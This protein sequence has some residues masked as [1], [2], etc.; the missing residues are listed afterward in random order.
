MQVHRQ[1]K[2]PDDGLLGAEDYMLADVG[3][4]KVEEDLLR[5]NI[6]GGSAGVGG[7]VSASALATTDP[8]PEPQAPPIGNEEDGSKWLKLLDTPRMQPAAPMSTCWLPLL[9]ARRIQKSGD[10]KAAPAYSN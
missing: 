6:G 4:M 8:G 5:C 9:P 2:F 7:G 1:R 10:V 3:F